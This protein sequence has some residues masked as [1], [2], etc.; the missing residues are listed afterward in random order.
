M[1]C[2][3]FSKLADITTVLQWNFMETWEPCG[4]CVLL[5]DA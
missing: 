1:C 3:L 5:G 4:D 2:K